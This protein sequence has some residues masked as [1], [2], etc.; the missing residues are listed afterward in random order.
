M[1]E[2][3]S[4]AAQVARAQRCRSRRQEVDLSRIDRS[5]LIAR[6]VEAVFDL[7]NEVEGYPRL[8][9][10]C[11]SASVVDR[12]DDHL[13]ARLDLQYAGFRSEFTTRNRVQRPSII[14]ISLL[15]GP[16]S[17]LR[18]SWSLHALGD[19]GCRVELML[20]FDFAGRLFGSALAIGFQ[21][22]ADRMVDEFA[23]AARALP[24]A[25]PAMPAEGTPAEG[26]PR[27]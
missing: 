25:V 19:L 10:W 1:R 27:P 12:S 16:F 6:P 14:E 9:D 24:L 18:G 17:R 26:T 20:D 7:I 21:G 23:R 4:S 2:N 22:L 15:E 8:F 3:A 13:T 5:A 11:R